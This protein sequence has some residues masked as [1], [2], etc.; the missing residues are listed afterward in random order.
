MFLKNANLI[1]IVGYGRVILGGVAGSKLLPPT[2]PRRRVILPLCFFMADSIQRIELLC[3]IDK[4]YC[5]G[6]RRIG[7]HRFRRGGSL[8]RHTNGDLW[9]CFRL[10]TRINFKCNFINDS[11]F[12]FKRDFLEPPSGGRGAPRTSCQ[13]GSLIVLCR[14]ACKYKSSL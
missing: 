5:P 13:C 11:L 12:N 7:H 6:R 8:V 3:V 9:L 14:S 10:N 4:F 2:P 1:R